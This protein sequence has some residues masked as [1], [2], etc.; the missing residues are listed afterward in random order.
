MS[1][2]T[3]RAEQALL[4]GM[5]ANQEIPEQIRR[6]EAGDFGGREHRQLFSTIS[7]IR[8]DAPTLGGEY[9][10]DAVAARSAD[11]SATYR[12]LWALRT[13][14][15]DPRHITAYAKMVQAAAFRR[16]VATHAE[17]IA[18]EAAAAP[19]RDRT[20]Y[21]TELAEALGHQV[22][23]YE[24]LTTV[25]PDRVGRALG[26]ASVPP[27][28]EKVDRRTRQE[29]LLLADLLQN[30]RQA[31]E[32]ARFV[33]DTTFRDPQ[34]R[35]VYRTMLTLAESGDPID[36]VIVSW[37]MALL[38]GVARDYGAPVDGQPQPAEPDDVY[39]NRL[40]TTMTKVSAVE[41][42]RSLVAEDIR[43]STRARSGP[44]TQALSPAQPAARPAVRP[45]DP[46][47]PRPANHQPGPTPQ[48]GR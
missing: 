7:T 8:R 30:P 13:H 45:I 33:P 19:Q 9:L 38:R 28:A 11:P 20:K 35:E 40:A 25:E 42:G 16:E 39:L 34:R 43:T 18:T 46:T 12:Y 27:P 14:C 4:G 1:Y 21:A 15:P 10:M 3:L 23:R 32:I 2:L 26:R 37:Q 24:A 41:I 47:L 29:D 44:V 36:E 31:L 22:R 5:L 17:R 6:V 48:P